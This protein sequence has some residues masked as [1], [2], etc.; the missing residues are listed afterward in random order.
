[1]PNPLNILYCMYN[2]MK[3]SSQQ[4]NEVFE[5]WVCHSA[6]FHLTAS[7]ALLASSITSMAVLENHSAILCCCAAR[8]SSGCT[9]TEDGKHATLYETDF[10]Y[11]TNRSCRPHEVAIDS[12]ALFLKHHLG[13]YRMPY[14]LHARLKIPCPHIVY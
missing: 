4:H 10:E 2:N 8:L 9:L 13:P 12:A 11:S 5:Y 7:I 1:M 3:I 6:F 14:S